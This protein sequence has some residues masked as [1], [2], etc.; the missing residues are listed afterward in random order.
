M[1]EL[2]SSA[3]EI[4]QVIQVQDISELK[5]GKSWIGCSLLP[6]SVLLSSLA[7]E[8]FGSLV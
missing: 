2:V 3:S 8:L 5:M 7:T 6:V 4:W 1:A